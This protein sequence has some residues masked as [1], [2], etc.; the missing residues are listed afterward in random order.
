MKEQYDEESLN[1][2]LE[3][4]DTLEDS[5]YKTSLIVGANNRLKQLRGEEIPMMDIYNSIALVKLAMGASFVHTAAEPK[6]PLNTEELLEICYEYV[7]YA[8]CGSAMENMRVQ[9]H[10]AL[11]EF[12][13]P[14]LH[15]EIT[16]K[17]LHC[18]DKEIDLPIGYLYDPVILE[19]SQ[20]KHYGTLLRGKLLEYIEKEEEK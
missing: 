9:A 16:D 13:P 1:N 2:L 4:A 17:L 19:H 18:M 20:I 12:F 10:K 15:D 5:I 6:K 7:S 8:A 14:H 11:L 3:F